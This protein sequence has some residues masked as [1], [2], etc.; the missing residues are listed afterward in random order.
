[1]LLQLI[2]FRLQNFL[3]IFPYS[4][5][6]LIMFPRRQVQ[7]CNSRMQRQ[8]LRDITLLPYTVTD[9]TLSRMH[10]ALAA[11]LEL[12]LFRIVERSNVR[13]ICPLK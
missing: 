6:L 10:I 4:L 7:R 11:I 3:P 2:I 8:H 9:I 12:C 5:T 1:M 13:W